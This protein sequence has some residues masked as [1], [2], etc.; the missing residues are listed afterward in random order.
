MVPPLPSSLPN[1]K[2]ACGGRH[3]IARGV[4]PGSTPRPCALLSFSKC[5]PRPWWGRHLPTQPCQREGV[6][7]HPC[8]RPSHRRQP[9]AH[10]AVYRSRKRSDRSHDATNRAIRQVGLSSADWWQSRNGG[11][12]RSGTSK[13]R[14]HQ[15]RGLGN[16]KMTK[17]RKGAAVTRGLHPGLRHAARR[18]RA[19]SLGEMRNRDGGGPAF[20]HRDPAETH[21]KFTNVACT[22]SHDPWLLVI[23]HRQ[24]SR[25]GQSPGPAAAAGGRCQRR[26]VQPGLARSERPTKTAPTPL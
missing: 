19:W 26:P 6:R 12:S 5:R 20:T 14:P 25:E 23:A 22:V 1:T 18:R 7:R 10:R 2:P 9:P 16:W 15:G 17:E 21:T 24:D 3:A 4:N 8:D 11:W 13:C